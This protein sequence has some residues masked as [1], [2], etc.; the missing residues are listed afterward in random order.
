MVRAGG[1]EPPISPFRGERINQTFLRPDNGAGYGSCTRDDGLED[2][3][4]AATPNPHISST[5]SGGRESNPRDPPWQ[6]GTW[7]LCHPRILVYGLDPPPPA[8]FH[9]EVSRTGTVDVVWSRRIELRWP[10]LQ[11]GVLPSEL[12]PH[13]GSIPRI[14]TWRLLLNREPRSPSS[15]GWNT[16]YKN[17]LQITDIQ[18]SIM[19]FCMT[20]PTQQNTFL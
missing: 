19:H 9:P 18:N 11:G 14:R 3:H 4:V 2:H 5:W 20:I 6:G 7:P 10:P 13:N 17:Q 1:F 12:R 15:V 16:L 8:Q